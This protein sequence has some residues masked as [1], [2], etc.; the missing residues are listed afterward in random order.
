MSSILHKQLKDRG[1]GLLCPK[2]SARLGCTCGT[3]W[4]CALAR[5]RPTESSTSYTR[6]LQSGDLGGVHL[7]L[8]GGGRG[9]GGGG[10]GP[11]G[12][13]VLVVRNGPGHADGVVRVI[14]A[15]VAVGER[16]VRRVHVR[17]PVL[18][19]VAAAECPV[20]VLA[21]HREVAVLRP[22]PATSSTSCVRLHHAR[23]QAQSN[24]LAPAD[25]MAKRHPSYPETL[26]TKTAACEGV[27]NRSGTIGIA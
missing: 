19:A 25:C 23:C 14:H 13:H 6:A 7:L 27:P 16:A 22:R 2:R 12:R 10:G 24:S 9:G 5:A 18:E 17:Y 4:L 1:L 3:I 26:C 11:T 8:G 20:P 15:D 21:H